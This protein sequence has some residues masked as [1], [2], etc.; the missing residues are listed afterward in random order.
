MPYYNSGTITLASG[1]T[2]TS[3]GA[4]SFRLN[5]IYD[6]KIETVSYAADPTPAAQAADATIN[7]PK[8]RAYWMQFYRYWTVVKS[9]YRIRFWDESVLRDGEIEIYTYHHGQQNP[10]LVEHTTNTRI[11]RDYRKMH[12]NMHMSKIRT[13]QDIVDAGTGY[14]SSVFANQQKIQGHYHPGSVKHEVA[15]DEL[16]ETWHRAT[17]VPPLAENV[18]FILQRSQRATDQQYIIKFEIEFEYEVQ[19]KDL[20]AQYEYFGATSAIPAIASFTAQTN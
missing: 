13:R 15:E 7:T 6:S 4:L 18:T 5:S 19:L 11:T 9:R 20:A 17:E 2:S 12:P 3:V 8:F 10:P 16:V 14:R 1:A